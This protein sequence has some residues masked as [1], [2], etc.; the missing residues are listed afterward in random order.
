MSHYK[1]CSRKCTG[2]GASNTDWRVKCK[3]DWQGLHDTDLGFKRVESV[4]EHQ[5]EHRLVSKGTVICTLCA[6]VLCT[7]YEEAPYRSATARY[8]PN[9]HRYDYK[10]H[11]HRHLSSVKGVPND[12]MCRVRATFA[13]MYRV[14]FKLFPKRKNFMSYGFV[15]RKIMEAQGLS[16]YTSTLSVV[17]TPCKIK[18]CEHAWK[19]MCEELGI[20]RDS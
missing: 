17:K 9:I 3:P 6:T 12:S 10:T 4:C 5:S 19:R 15:L 14:F 1:R 13:R 16:Q 8:T 20:N 7:T 18:E 2:L 11:L